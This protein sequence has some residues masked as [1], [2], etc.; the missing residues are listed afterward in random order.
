MSDDIANKKIEELRR[1]ALADFSDSEIHSFI[2]MGKQLASKSVLSMLIAVIEEGPSRKGL[3]QRECDRLVK[4]VKARMPYNYC[5]YVQCSFDETPFLLNISLSI[6][7]AAYRTEIDIPDV[8]YTADLYQKY[9]FLKNTAIAYWRQF[10]EDN[11]EL[12]DRIC[13]YRADVDFGALV[14]DPKNPTVMYFDPLSA[15]RIGIFCYY[16]D[17]NNN[18]FYKRKA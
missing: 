10:A 15:K 11:K 13:N 7:D 16:V 6:V 17:Q 5:G 3:D 8:R 1:R 14:I 4:K 2:T 9:D 18:P 12:Y